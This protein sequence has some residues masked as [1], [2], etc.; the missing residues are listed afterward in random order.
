MTVKQSDKCSVVS[1]FHNSAYGGGPPENRRC[2]L[3][4]EPEGSYN[5]GTEK[6]PLVVPCPNEYVSGVIDG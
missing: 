5:L 3:G 6:K 2:K 1:C 4:H